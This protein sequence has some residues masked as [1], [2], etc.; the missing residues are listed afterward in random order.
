MSQ[1]A[2]IRRRRQMANGNKHLAKLRRPV[3]PKGPGTADAA[4]KRDDRWRANR[5]KGL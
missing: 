5:A 3:Y 1:R 4:K 2:A